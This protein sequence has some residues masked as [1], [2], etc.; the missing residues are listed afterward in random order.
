MMFLI[1]FDGQSVSINW[2]IQK[3]QSNIGENGINILIVAIKYYVMLKLRT[4]ERNIIVNL[5]LFGYRTG[6]RVAS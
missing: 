3:S 4:L 6:A 2:Q 5:V 1:T